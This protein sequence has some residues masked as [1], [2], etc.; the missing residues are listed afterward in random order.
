MLYLSRLIV[1]VRDRVAR[2]DLGDVH[3][4]H[5]TILGAFPQAPDSDT[6]RQ[7]F[8]IL[9]RA[10]PIPDQPLLARILVQ[11]SYEPTWSHLSPGYLAPAPDDRGNP[12][13]RP[14]DGEYERL[15]AGMML[16]FRLRANPTQ[17]ISQNNQQQDEK[18]RGKRVELRREEDQLRWI[19]RKA[20]H[21]GFRLL[22]I[23][24]RP[25]L[26]D[27][28]ISPQAK[29]IGVRSNEPTR[30]RMTFGAALF[31]GL[32][33]VQDVDRFRHTLMTGVGSGKA[34]GFGLLSIA[35]IS[36]GAA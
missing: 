35:S 17:R 27:V 7:H 3:Q 23:A 2:Q 1:N 16:R 11:S 21:S 33:Q 36:G 32:L 24:T 9:F 34:Y 5:R 29:V 28:C 6:A 20:E 12:A 25:D 13:V 26:V 18:W 31:E 15:V 10:E 19:G 8:G 30:P 22:S 14:L 4:L